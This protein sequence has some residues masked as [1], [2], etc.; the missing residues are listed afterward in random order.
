MYC[1]DEGS[2]LCFPSRTFQLQTTRS[3]EFMGLN[4]KV[5]RNS[6]VESDIIVGVIDT[7]IWPESESFKD[8]GF[9]P[10]PKSWKGVCDGGKNFTC[11]KYVPSIFFF[12][13]FNHITGSCKSS[14]VGDLIF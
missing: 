14:L 12:H 9:G 10:P 4:E 1:R 13:L 5:S 3:W 11:N 7:G 8:D 6:V 2:S